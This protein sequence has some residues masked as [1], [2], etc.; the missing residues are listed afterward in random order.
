M[1]DKSDSDQG[2]L[3]PSGKRG[4]ST[5]PSS[6]VRRGL[7]AIRSQ[8]EH[9]FYFPEDGRW[10][11]ALLLRNGN[12]I[13]DLC[14][15]KGRCTIPDAEELIFLLTINEDGYTDQFFLQVI[16]SSNLHGIF[17]DGIKTITNNMLL[18]VELTRPLRTLSFGHTGFSNSHLWALRRLTTLREL[19]LLCTCISDDGL[20]YLQ[21]FTALKRLN[22][23]GTQITDAGL[24][25]LRKLT[26]LEWLSLIDTEIS[27][28][29]LT[30]H[31][32]GLTSLQT[33]WLS[34]TQT[35]DAELLALKQ[36]LPN[37]K[38]TEM[39]LQPNLPPWEALGIAAP[40]FET[41]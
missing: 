7:E 36:V 18:Y 2:R 24:I 9:I 39:K 33:L 19:N 11:C 14:Q 35:N 20:K 32:S 25:S 15:G 4:L 28:E 6:L 38:I 21:E 1:S 40:I 27:A 16:L 31:L 3:V 10:N 17:F 37:C 5:R 30:K 23:G 13:T 34:S 22:L 41:R 29:G 12:V 26:S 8:Q